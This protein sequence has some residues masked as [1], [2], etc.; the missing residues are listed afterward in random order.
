[1]TSPED[2]K[3]F[4]EERRKEFDGPCSK[5]NSAPV[6]IVFTNGALCTEC[7]LKALKEA[8]QKARRSEFN[9]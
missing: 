4:R 1:M 6:H 7:Y 2:I 8:M 3:K 5:C 9:V